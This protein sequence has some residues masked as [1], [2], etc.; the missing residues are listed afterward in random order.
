M[1]EVDLG[2][3]ALGLDVEGDVSARPL[4]RVADEAEVAVEHVPGDPPTGDQFGDPLGAAVLVLVAVGELVAELV[5]AA[6]DIS[7]PPAADV[8]DGGEDL[9][10]GLVEV[11][12][13]VKFWLIVVSLP[14]RLVCL[15][16]WCALEIGVPLEVGLP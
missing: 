11:N 16:D 7:C 4:G 2:L 5:G 1:R 13:V 8:V 3:L 12:V 6:L 9:V 10:R 14:V 15:G